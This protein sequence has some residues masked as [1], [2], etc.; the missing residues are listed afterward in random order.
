MW[1]SNVVTLSWN[2]LMILPDQ[3]HW[4]HRLF[5]LL[6]LRRPWKGGRFGFFT[7]VLHSSSN[8]GRR[9]CVTDSASGISI[10]RHEYQAVV[11]GIQKS[12]YNGV[13]SVKIFRSSWVSSALLQILLP[14]LIHF[15]PVMG[16]WPCQGSKCQCGF[17]WLQHL[18]CERWDFY[19]SLLTAPATS[20]K[21]DSFFPI[22][23][24]HYSN[25]S[26]LFLIYELTFNLIWWICKRWSDLY[27]VND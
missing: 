24:Q 11:Y 20:A 10:L 27:T 13:W 8:I 25:L 4:L 3:L 2:T 22:P 15:S 14:T 26:L 6:L 7:F 1:I 23:I 19:W 21:R 9:W 16:V 5:I 17:W 18:R 12:T